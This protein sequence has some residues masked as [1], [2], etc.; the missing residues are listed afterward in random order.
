MRKRS[1]TISAAVIALAGTSAMAKGTLIPI[2]PVP[3]STSTSVFAIN[4]SDIITGSWLDP[5]GVEHGYV[6]PLSGSKY[7]TFDDTNSPSPGTEPRAINDNGTI[8]GLSNSQNGTTSGDIPFERDP[9]GKT[10]E[11]TKNGALL[12]Y[13]V[14][15]INNTNNTF[16]GSYINSS[17]AVIGYLAENGKYKS[18]FK[19]T[20]LQNNGYAG[21]GVD[22]AGDIVG[23]YDDPAGVQ[24]GLLVSGGK[25]Q[26]LEPSETNLASSVLEGINDK[27]TISG[28]WTDTAGLIHAFTYSMTSK[29]FTNINVPG[30]ASFVQAW[31]ISDQ[32]L[33]AVGSDVGYYIY[34]P[35]GVNCPAGAHGS[36]KPAAKPR[37]QLP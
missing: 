28:W 14:Q 22:N 32:G 18:A 29:K 1:M 31:G 12:N 19:V 6:G 34:C 4:D 16:A 11:I 8:T 3:N 25:A 15:G 26:K 24:H 37:P 27:G 23:W 36:Y 13:L 35:S 17:L 21:R 10:T 5:S 20:G 33:V 30:S 2:V 7:Q 9:K